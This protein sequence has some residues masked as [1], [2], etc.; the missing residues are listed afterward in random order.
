MARPSKKPASKDS[1][2]YIELGKA[3]ET[4]S[5]IKGIFAELFEE[6]IESVTD[7]I[8]SSISKLIYGGV[9]ATI[10]LF[11]S[12]VVGVWLFMASYQ[13][14]YLDT[15]AALTAKI[16]ALQKENTDL[17]IELKADLQKLESQQDYIERFLIEIQR[18]SSVKAVNTTGV[19]DQN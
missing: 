16:E 12:L 8:K 7:E 9:I 3:A 1:G 17:K 19:T 14:H 4:S 18:Q 6:K 15:Q 13:Q 11:I 2:A 5:L 10:L